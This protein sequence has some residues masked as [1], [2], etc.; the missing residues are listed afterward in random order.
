MWKKEILHE[1]F[2]F[3]VFL[4]DRDYYN[5]LY[6]YMKTHW[7]GSP[8]KSIITRYSLEPDFW[9]KVILVDFD[10]KRVHLIYY[11]K[12]S[13]QEIFSYTVYQGGF[14]EKHEIRGEWLGVRVPLYSTSRSELYEEYKNFTLDLYFDQ[15]FEEIVEKAKKVVKCNSS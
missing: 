7:N 10:V 15:I 11:K 12:T 5:F 1:D 9:S 8:K 2:D 4:Y 6:V 14:I 13:E 3:K